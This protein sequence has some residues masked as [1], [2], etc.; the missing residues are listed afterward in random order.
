[1]IYTKIYMICKI[2]RIDLLDFQGFNSRNF[3]KPILFEYNSFDFN[4]SILFEFR[5]FG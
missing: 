4:K 5:V 1:M 2:F 3:R